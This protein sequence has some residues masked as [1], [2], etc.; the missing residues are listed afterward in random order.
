MKYL[1]IISIFLSVASVLNA[2]D[3]PNVIL[4]YADD[5]SKGM[6]SAYG[7][8]QFTT[9]AI[10]RLFNG[11]VSFNYAYGSGFS[12]TALA[13]LITGYN[14]YST[15]NRRISKGGAFE[16]IDTMMITKMEQFIEGSNTALPHN[17]YYLPQL[18]SAAGY[19]TAQIGMLGWGKTTSRAQIKSHGWDYFYGYLD[20]K[21]SKGYYPPFL[22]ENGNVVFVEGNTR[23]DCG[24][25]IMP[26][27]QTA[28]D[29]RHNIEGKA[30]YAPDLFLEKS[31]AFIRQNKSV[32]FF[33][34]YSSPLPHGPVA[35]PAIDA[36]IAANDNLSQIEK[37]YASMIKYFDN[38]I[39]III[40]E[41]QSLGIEKNT[42]IVFTSGNGHEICYRQDGRIEAPYIDKSNK[43]RFDGSYSKYYGYKA[44]DVFNGNG[45]LAGLKGSNLEG[46]IRVPLVFYQKGKLTKRSSDEIV[47]GYDFLPMMADMLNV[48]LI[49][50][51]DGESYLK[52][53]TKNSRLPKNKYIVVT[54]DEGPAIIGN[55]GWKLRYFSPKKTYELYDIR[56][57]PAEKY[58]LSMRY[59]EKV[60]AMTKKLLEMTGGNLM[61]G[62]IYD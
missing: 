23:S 10:D 44:G 58:D 2:A 40:K 59:P 15:K 12:Y 30:V 28:F 51:K 49:F 8:K 16:V 53:L 34:M 55:D 9:P 27:T 42:L 24:R 45:D 14:D 4:I 41:I 32:P 48:K 19:M 46:G 54:A 1:K 37:E 20:H 57:D 50:P 29:D 5:L 61:S 11:G 52:T 36:E 43:S 6:L 18:F 38:Q 21:R 26:E 39:D 17:D 31:L 25:S 35:V 60:E 3:R 33:L 13:S 22:F 62:V 56:K 7:Q 47:A